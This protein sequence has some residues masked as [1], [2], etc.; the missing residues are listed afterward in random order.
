MDKTKK[1]ELI[2]ISITAVVILLLIIAGITL[3]PSAKTAEV[4]P[5]QLKSYENTV[6]LYEGSRLVE[7]YDEI[8]VGA[9]PKA[10]QSGLAAGIGFKTLSEARAAAEDYDG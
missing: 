9:L 2:I 5:Y 6:A 8:E 3:K 10:D 4:Y 7:V 1:I